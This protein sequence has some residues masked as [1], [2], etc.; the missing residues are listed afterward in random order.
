MRT[1]GA[2][3]AGPVRSFRR[4]RL[5]PEDREGWMGTSERWPGFVRE[6]ASGRLGELCLLL[7]KSPVEPG[8]QSLEIRC[9]YGSAAPDAQARR[10]VPVGADV[11]GSPFLFQRRR[12]ALCDLR[13]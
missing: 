8:C 3:M 13:D 12:H 2:G 1:R 11:Q 9:L 6:E 10:G 4:G 7:G 5:V